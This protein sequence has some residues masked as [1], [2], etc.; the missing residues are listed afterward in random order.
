[1]LSAMPSEAYALHIV[2][3]SASVVLSSVSVPL[4]GLCVISAHVNK[5]WRGF[6]LLVDKMPTKRSQVLHLI[7]K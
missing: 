7:P 2:G 5:A 6:N 1:M 3:E 4:I